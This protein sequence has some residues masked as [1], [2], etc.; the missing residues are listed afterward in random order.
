MLELPRSVLKKSPCKSEL[1]LIRHPF[2][3]RASIPAVSLIDSGK[4][5]CFIEAVK[6][7]GLCQ[8]WHG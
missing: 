4:L 1:L 2:C 8:P 6:L 3:L 5:G 7:E